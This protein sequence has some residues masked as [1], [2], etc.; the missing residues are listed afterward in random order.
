MSQSA[1]VSLEHGALSR[2][3]ADFLIE[4]SIALHKNAI[5]PQGHPLLDGAVAGV[6]RRLVPLLESRGSLSLGVARHQLVIEGV[7]TEDTNPLLRELAGK[8]H[9]HCL[10]AVRIL[11]GV[12]HDELTAFLRAVGED[13]WRTG[14]PL[15]GEGEGAAQQWPHVRLYALTYAQ[16]ELLDEHEAAPGTEELHAPGED[17]ATLGRTRGAQLWIG[18]ARAALATGQGAGAAAAKGET[19]ETAEKETSAPSTDPV[20][21][22]RAID[23]NSRDVAYDQV[24]VGYLLQIAEELKTK[25]GKEAASL[26]RRISRLVSTLKPETLRRLLDMGGDMPQRR[27]FVLDASQGLAVDAVV[28]LV[29]AAADTSRQTIS[30]SMVRLLSK[31]A[32]HAEQGTASMRPQ[33]DG[34]L[35]EQVQTLMRGWELED[36]NP[37]A[38]RRALEGMARAAPLLETAEQAFPPE[39]DRLLQMSLELGIVNEALFRAADSY[40]ARGRLRQLLDLLDAAPPSVARAAAWA[41]VGTPELLRTVAA[42]PEPDLALLERIARPLGYAACDPLLDAIEEAAERGSAD[43]RSARALADVLAVAGADARAAVAGRI[44]GARWRVQRTMLATLARLG[45]PPAGFVSA[46]YLAHPAPE[47]RREA[48]LLLAASREDR[49]EALCAALADADPRIVRL[50]L[51]ESL[52]DCPEEAVSVLQ[53]RAEDESLPAELRTLAV[54]VVAASGVAG[55]QGWLLSLVAGKRRLMGGV[56][57]AAKTPAMVAALAA[58]AERWRGESEVEPVLEAARASADPELRQAVLTRSRATAELT[59]MPPSRPP[60]SGGTG[61]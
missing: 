2:D 24:V 19:A 33:A 12:T 17:G 21:V 22:A 50:G 16:L 23:E 1:A 37:D 41:H 8:L 56:R 5:Y 60:A 29:Q 53:V 3:L 32:L 48:F 43:D 7:A 11:K 51:K 36:P 28:E 57:L 34:A 26:Q 52:T 9:R 58:L 6:E 54:R 55:I 20:V 15:G 44:D 31:F 4:L 49:T 14:R 45:G 47:V 61:A 38:Y 35:R 46:P 27:R 30:H 42:D 25:R 40:V 39:P 59:A 13:A 18:L 10:G